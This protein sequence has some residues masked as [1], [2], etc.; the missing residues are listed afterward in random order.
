MK[1]FLTIMNK[2]LVHS[3]LSAIINYRYQ[4]NIL[5]LTLILNYIFKNVIN[6][7]IKTADQ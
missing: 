4:L 2:Y 3:Y 1:K 7:S 5:V 6:Q